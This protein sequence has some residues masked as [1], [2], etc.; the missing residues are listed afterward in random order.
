M[1]QSM[2][3]VRGLT[4]V[5]SFPYE[6]TQAKYQWAEILS[7]AAKVKEFDLLLKNSKPKIPNPDTWLLMC[8]DSCVIIQLGYHL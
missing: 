2:K 5:N 4:F 1:R 6:V 8:G 7:S 3:V